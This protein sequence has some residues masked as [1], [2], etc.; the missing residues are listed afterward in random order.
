MR[1]PRQ[2][3]VIPFR[4][5]SNSFEFLILKRSNVEMWQAVSGGV[6]DSE[7]LKEAATR[8]LFEETA[9]RSANFIELDTIAS[10]PKY[11]YPDHDLWPKELYVVNEYA[12]GTEVFGEPILSSEHGEYAWL[13]LESAMQIVTFDSN[14]TALWELHERIRQ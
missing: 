4:K 1:Q 5:H 6:E 13:D 12:F 3:L 8:E 14:R 7:S 9:F 10:I 11:I 2:V